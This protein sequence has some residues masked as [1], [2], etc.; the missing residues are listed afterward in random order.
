MWL[1]KGPYGAGQHLPGTNILVLAPGEKHNQ[2]KHRIEADRGT[3]VLGDRDHQNPLT[4]FRKGWKNGLCMI[5]NLHR[6]WE[7][8]QGRGSLPVKIYRHQALVCG[9][10]TGPGHPISCFHVGTRPGDLFFFLPL[11]LL[12][13]IFL[14]SLSPSLFIQTPLLCTYRGTQGLL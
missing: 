12:S 5:T 13:L 14:S 2:H 8:L 7:T 6:K 1:Q 9:Y 11:S 10:P 3:W 4:C